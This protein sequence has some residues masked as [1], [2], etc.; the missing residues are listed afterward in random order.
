VG[1]SGTGKNYIAKALNLRSLPS[2]AT[3]PKRDGETDGVE[4]IFVTIKSW[5]TVYSHQKNIVAYTFFDGNHYWS[6]LEQ[7]E[8]A[9]YDVY[10]IDPAGVRYFLQNFGDK[11]QRQYSIVYIKTSIR[12]RIIRMRQRKDPW[13]KIIKRLWNDIV[14]F[15]GFEKDNTIPKIVIEV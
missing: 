8:S 15:R 2:F 3:R 10:I 11:I 9:D 4:H 5:E 12:K 1:C 6:T 14:E 13:K 7:L